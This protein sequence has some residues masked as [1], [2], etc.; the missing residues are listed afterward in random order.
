MTI[1]NPGSALG[2]A[3][4]IICEWKSRFW[5]GTGHCHIVALLVNLEVKKITGQSKF[6]PLYHQY[7]K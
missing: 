6:L 2:Q 3:I 1:G 5:L 7:I 4:V